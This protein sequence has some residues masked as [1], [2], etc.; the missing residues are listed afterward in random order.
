MP[1]PHLTERQRKY[2]ASLQASLERETGKT[3]DAWVAIARTCPETGHRA[4]LRWLKDN[5]GLLQNHGSHVLSEAFESAMS[6]QEPD[7]LLEALWVDPASSAI[8]HAVDVAAR[9][10]GEVILGPRK[11]YTAWSRNFQFA[12]AK[13]VKGGKLMLGLALAPDASA[14]LETPKNESWSER[15]KARTLLASPAEVDSEIG[16]L[17]RAAWERS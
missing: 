5:Y 2:F 17:L 16:P 15:L 9:A 6:W 7:K 3:L 12:A 8:F 14:R 4:R 1:E 10:P 11:G 13:P